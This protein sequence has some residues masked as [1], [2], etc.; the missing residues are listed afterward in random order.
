MTAAALPTTEPS[1]HRAIAA[2]TI[3]NVREWL[4]TWERAFAPLG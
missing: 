4:K 3:G 2:G 1:Y